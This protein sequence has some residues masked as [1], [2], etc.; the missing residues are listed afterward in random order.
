VAS[1]ISHT[2]PEA[3]NYHTSATFAPPLQQ[4]F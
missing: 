3:P 4:Q 2:E 1:P